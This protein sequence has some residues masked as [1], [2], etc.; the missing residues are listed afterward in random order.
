MSYVSSLLYRWPVNKV[1]LTR[2]ELDT[3]LIERKLVDF[4]T[5][6]HGSPLI[7]FWEKDN[8]VTGYTWSAHR[9]IRNLDGTEAKFVSPF[10]S[11]SKD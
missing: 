9:E 2:M 5:D 4:S 1:Y 10:T 11:Y 8:I 6:Y 7:V 3:E